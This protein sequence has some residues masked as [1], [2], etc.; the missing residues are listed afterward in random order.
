MTETQIELNI[1]VD[2]NRQKLG[3]ERKHWLEFLPRMLE[4]FVLKK[5]KRCN[6]LVILVSA[7]GEKKK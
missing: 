2:W 7:T 4:R 6:I 3:R 5:K 1:L